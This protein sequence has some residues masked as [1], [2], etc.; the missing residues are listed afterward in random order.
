MKWWPFERK[1]SRTA[2]VMQSL[3]SASM[4][5]REFSAYSKEGYQKNVVAYRCVRTI[6]DAIGSIPILLYEGETELSDHPLLKLIDRPNPMHS[7]DTF[8]AQAVSYKL[9][10]GNNYMERVGPESGP[11]RELYNLR[12]DRVN[13][14]PGRGIPAAYKYSVSGGEPVVFEV[15]RVTGES[16]I[17]H[18]KTF[19]PLDE[20][21]GMPPLEAAAYAVDQHNAAGEWNFNL[22]RN[23]GKPPGAL[24]SDGELTDAQFE[25]L[26]AQMDDLYIGP[27]NAGRPGLFE[28][29][30]KWEQMA[31]SPTDM[32][33][34]RGRDMAARDVALAFKVP[35][36]IVGVE[37]S[38]TF[39]NFEQARLALYEDAILPEAYQLVDGLNRWLAP[40]FGDRLRLAID[41]DKIEALQARRT[42]VWERVRTADFL[43]VNEKR[44]ALGYDPVEGGDAVLQ[45]AAMLPLGY[46]D[47]LPDTAGAARS[48]YGVEGDDFRV[49]IAEFLTSE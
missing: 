3:P 40:L 14:K 19:N 23:S 34:L 24:V 36:Q 6:A 20:W 38:M 18:W 41:E 45:P 9:L 25:R 47:P 44:E 13:I 35:P 32:D 11:P 21:Y 8:I 4:M 16:H 1:E 39:A 29:G 10:S 5:R 43:T 30:L 17:W 31:L 28:S 26:K 48:A 2:A 12:P 33:W 22:L 49:K 42:Q 7:G 37:G 15:D 46:E 27:S